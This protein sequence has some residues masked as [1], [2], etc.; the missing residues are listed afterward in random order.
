MRFYQWLFVV[1]MVVEF[2]WA[3]YRH[4]KPKEGDSN[5]MYYLFFVGPLALILYLGGFFG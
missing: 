2:G 5:I 4:G 3:C 1:W